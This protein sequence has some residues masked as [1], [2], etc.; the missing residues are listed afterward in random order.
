MTEET[1]EKTPATAPSDVVSSIRGFVAAAGGS[2]KAV[3]QPTGQAGVRVTLVGEEGGLLGDRV[4]ADVATAEAVVD[5][6]DGLETAEWDRELT[7]AAN[8]T[9]KHWRKMAGWVAG[10]KRFPKARNRKILD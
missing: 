5:A 3:L 2:A 4:V 10:Q 9:P 8:V 7:S 6:V 1:A